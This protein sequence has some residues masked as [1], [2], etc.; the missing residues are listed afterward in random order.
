M[1]IYSP[2]ANHQSS[3]HLQFQPLI[4][5]RQSWPSKGSDT[6]AHF[7]NLLG[8]FFGSSSLILGKFSENCFLQKRK[9]AR[10]KRDGWSFLSK[11]NARFCER[12]NSHWRNHQRLTHQPPLFTLKKTFSDKLKTSALDLKETVVRQT[13]S[14]SGNRAQDYTLYTGALRATCLVFKA[15]QVTKN[16][17]DL[18]LG[19]DI[20][21]ACDSTSKDYG[22]VTFICG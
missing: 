8:D 10:V 4:P 16:E 15:Y 20:V 18:K 11:G 5:K 3:N 1:K 17:N 9:L 2:S 21:K 6:K 19:S 14:L 13:W 22:R 7:G 12:N